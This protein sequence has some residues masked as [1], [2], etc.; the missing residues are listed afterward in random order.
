MSNIN[1]LRKLAVGLVPP[2]FY[3]AI[4]SVVNSRGLNLFL[5]KTGNSLYHPTWNTV[6]SGK[7][8]GLKLFIDSSSGEWEQTMA[9][10]TYDLHFTRYLQKMNLN[11]KV[12]FDIGA[13]I[14]YSS[15]IFETLSKGRG[16]V[17]AFEPNEFN[18]ERF[19]MHRNMNQ[20]MGEKI[21][22][23]PYAV[24]NE[25]GKQ[26]FVFT[27]NVDGWTSSGSFLAGA[28]TR[29]NGGVYEAELGF[30]RAKVR[31]VKL[32]SFVTR[33]KI[34][35]D[36]IKIDVEGAEFLVIAGGM[37]TLQKDK[38]IL[39]IELHSIFATVRT[40]EMLSSVGYV[41]QILDEDKDG[42]V[43]IAATSN[44]K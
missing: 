26:E 14:G 24:S 30:K 31:T 17:V 2:L 4:L 23:Y 32:D 11:G 39:L 19:E 41:T 43:Y 10:G 44:K 7:L 18:R 22:I 6:P 29:L 12:F 34:H 33:Q 37:K 15:L 21:S 42:R 20:K 5:R 40:L 36:I 35:P 8:K 13:H 1:Q 25:N 38:P 9:L 3:P 16:K 27:N 28:H